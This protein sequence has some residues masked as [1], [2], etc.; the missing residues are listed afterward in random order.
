MDKELGGGEGKKVWWEGEWWV[1]VIYSRATPGTLL[2]III[3]IITIITIIII[4]II[5]ITIIIILFSSSSW[6]TQGDISERLWRDYA[7]QAWD[8]SPALA[9]HLPVR[10]SS[11]DALL[12]EVRNRRSHG[13]W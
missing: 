3:I 2:V 13:C 4:I 8:I 9:V 1:G 5:T 12:K 10:F 6:R 7:R 11:S